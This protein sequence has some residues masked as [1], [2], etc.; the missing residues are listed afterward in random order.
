MTQD[1]R[2]HWIENGMLYPCQN[3]PHSFRAGPFIGEW[4]WA[5]DCWSSVAADGMLHN[6]L[7]AVYKLQSLDGFKAR[8]I[9]I[10]KLSVIFARKDQQ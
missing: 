9:I 5:G 1:V 7:V 4:Q 2:Q 6:H 3:K 8:R 10:G